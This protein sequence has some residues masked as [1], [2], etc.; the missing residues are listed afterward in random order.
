MA[1]PKNPLLYGT[2]ET[3]ILKTLEEGPRHGYGIARWL[4]AATDE[5]IQVDES[6]LYP[7]LY[8]LDEKGY[9]EAEW[10]RTEL[11][12]R[13]KFYRLTGKGRGELQ[14]ATS[15]WADFASAVSRVLLE[16]A[17]G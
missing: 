12:R 1:T 11:D 6:S 15:E 13:A 8:R 2:L 17:G 9:L 10:G 14:R 7:A 3:L 5:R 16:G 4:E